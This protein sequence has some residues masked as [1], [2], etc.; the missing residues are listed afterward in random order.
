MGAVLSPVVQERD[1]PQEHLEDPLTSYPE[2]GYWALPAG[3]RLRMLRA[4]CCD[5]LDTALIRLSFMSL[6]TP[7]VGFLASVERFLA[8]A[9]PQQA[10]L[11]F[12][13]HKPS[14]AWPNH[15][16]VLHTCIPVLQSAP[17]WQTKSPVH[18]G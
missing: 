4:L 13:T 6:P 17:Q 2:G 14:D 5:A 15:A 8:S 9:S 10:L 18:D 3:A 12:A 1:G 7:V 11:D 16:A